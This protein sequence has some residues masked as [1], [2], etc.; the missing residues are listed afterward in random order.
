MIYNF[1][2]YVIYNKKNINLLKYKLYNKI[3]V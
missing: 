3:I 2:L 1:W